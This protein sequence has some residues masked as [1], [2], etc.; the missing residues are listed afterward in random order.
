MKKYLL[1]ILITFWRINT[2]AQ[3]II[4]LKNGKTLSVKEKSAEDNLF[5]LLTDSTA[6]LD[7]IAKGNWYALEQTKFELAK[8]TLVKSSFVQLKNIAIILK[9]FPRLK[10]KIGCYSDITGNEKANIKLTQLRADAYKNYLLQLGVQ[11]SCILKT[12]GYSSQF[13]SCTDT[14]NQEELAKDRKIAIGVVVF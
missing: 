12:V 13:A 1:L 7:T 3:K 5:S 8:L 11:K 4:T 6:S 9:E 10:I 2:N 14:S